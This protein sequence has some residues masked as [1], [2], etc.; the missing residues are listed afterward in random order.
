M[1]LIYAQPNVRVEFLKQWS[2]FV[3]AVLSYGENHSKKSVNKMTS[4]IQ[5]SGQ[6]SEKRGDG[7]REQW[8]GS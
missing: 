3:T 8:G 7:R 4:D 5:E 2:K 6:F 1:G